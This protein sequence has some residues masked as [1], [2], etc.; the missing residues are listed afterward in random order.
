MGQILTV[1]RSLRGHDY[2]GPG[3][4]LPPTVSSYR[5]DC[6]AYLVDNPIKF[7]SREYRV[8]P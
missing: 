2:G 4:I 1:N 8:L 5:T 7:S 6:N 3:A